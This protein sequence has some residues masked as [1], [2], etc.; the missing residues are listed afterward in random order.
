MERQQKLITVFCHLHNT[1]C[2][3]VVSNSIT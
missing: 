2:Y 3:I 1:V